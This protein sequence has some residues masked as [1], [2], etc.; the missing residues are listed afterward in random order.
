[1]AGREGKDTSSSDHSEPHQP[2]L[3]AAEQQRKAESSH[4]RDVSQDFWLILTQNTLETHQILWAAMRRGLEFSLSQKHA[5][6]FP[7]KKVSFITY[8]QHGALKGLKQTLVLTKDLA[9][10]NIKSSLHKQTTS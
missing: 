1:M 4:G 8:L 2:G 9:W 10:D 6:L 7:R 3:T 5:D